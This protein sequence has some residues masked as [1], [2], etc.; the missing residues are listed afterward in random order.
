MDLSTIEKK[1]KGNQYA[2]IQ[3]FKDDM[4]LMFDNCYKFNGRD[5]PVGLMGQNVEKAFHNCLLKTPRSVSSNHYLNTSTRHEI[6]RR[7]S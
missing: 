4:Q 6:H 7:V 2:T 3:Q 1:L 5:S